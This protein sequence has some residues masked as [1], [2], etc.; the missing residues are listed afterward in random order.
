MAK[1]QRNDLSI[2]ADQKTCIDCN[3][4]CTHFVFRVG[5]KQKQVEMQLRFFEEW[6]CTV[7]YNQRLDC[8]EVAA[9]WACKHLQIDG[10]CGI[11]ENRPE[12][13]RH[14]NGKT[15]SI[16]MARNCKLVPVTVI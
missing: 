9:D 10:R 11:Y 5:G 16:T 15:Q 14:F 1:S 13:C 7:A 3:W 8:W 4:C 12:I 6:G 2:T